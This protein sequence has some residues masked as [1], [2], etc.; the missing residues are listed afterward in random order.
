VQTSSPLLVRSVRLVPVDRPAP[1]R[2]VDLRLRDGRVQEVGPRLSPRA[3]E[4]VLEADGRWV[5]PGLWDAHV[6][7]QTWARSVVRLDVSGM[8]GPEQVVTVVAG[9]LAGLPDDGAPVVGYGQRT[10]TWARTPTVGELDDVCGDR[11]VVLVSGDGHAGWV[12]EHAHRV[13][14]RAVRRQQ[15]HLDRHGQP[16]P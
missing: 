6:H 16:L 10:A 13:V 11:A 8:S 14:L 1:S 4:D 15:Q 7:L 12:A 9:H 3:D 5:V 2:P